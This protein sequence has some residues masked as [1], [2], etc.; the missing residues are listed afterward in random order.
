MCVC[1]CVCVCVS[2]MKAIW[3]PTNTM[4][5][6]VILSK[7][8]KKQKTETSELLPK[9]IYFK[10]VASSNRSEFPSPPANCEPTQCDGT[11]TRRC[12]DVRGFLLSPE[13]NAVECARKKGGKQ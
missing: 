7:K 3:K 12:C 10:W 13:G 5:A 11:T 6:V 9:Q 2:Q 8:T 4:S 1:V